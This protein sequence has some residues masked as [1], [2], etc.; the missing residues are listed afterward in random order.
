MQR[1]GNVLVLLSTL[2]MTLT[3]AGCGIPES[4]NK[5]STELRSAVVSFDSAI[6]AL[7]NQSANWQ[8]V[9]QNL[10][11]DL[12]SDTESMVRTEVENLMRTGSYNDRVRVSL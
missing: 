3:L 8:L 6:A 11:K 2:Y 5:I 12:V 1:K 10:E 7:S 9:L 4:I